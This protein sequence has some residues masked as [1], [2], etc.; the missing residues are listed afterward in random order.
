MESMVSKGEPPVSLFS[1]A[2]LPPGVN[3]TLWEGV[4]EQLL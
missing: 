4:K 3:K 2:K 1:P